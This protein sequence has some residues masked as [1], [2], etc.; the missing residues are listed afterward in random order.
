MLTLSLFSKNA[1]ED[2]ASPRGDTAP[3][4]VVSEG[5]K[6]EGTLEFS[7]VNLRIEGVVHGD[8]TTDGRVIVAEGAEVEGTINAHTIRL[9]GYVEGHLRADDELVLGP[10]SEVHATIEADVLEIQ[11]GADFS[12]EVPERVETASQEDDSVP[13]RDDGEHLGEPAPSGNGEVER[14]T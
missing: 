4:S 8:I 14:A 2:S 13:D 1:S 5:A 7:D 3:T 9:A 11:P 6:I 10:T 12:G